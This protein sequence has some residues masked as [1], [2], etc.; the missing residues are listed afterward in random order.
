MEEILKTTRERLGLYFQ[1]FKGGAL[2][3]EDEALLDAKFDAWRQKNDA[4]IEGIVMGAKWSSRRE[5][6]V[7]IA[8][9]TISA[10]YMADLMLGKA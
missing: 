7:N 9:E 8:A 2:E 6:L 10:R 3:S 5:R 4:L 1:G